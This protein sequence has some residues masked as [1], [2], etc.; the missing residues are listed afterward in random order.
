MRCLFAPL[1]LAILF[2]HLLLASAQAAAPLSAV[3][4][5]DS[6]PVVPSRL[7]LAAA[8]TL[9][10]QGNPGLRA[11]TRDVDI[12]AAQ[13][14]QAGTRPN[15]ALSYLSE[16]LQNDRRTT[17]VQ[18]DQTIELGGKRGARV[19]SAEREREIASADLASYRSELRADVVTAFFDVLTAQERLLLAQG[20]EQLSQQ[21]IKVA[22]HRVIAGK[23]SPV[24]ETRARV[25]G[26]SSRIELNQ[27][28]NQLAQ[29]RARLAATWGSTAPLSVEVEAPEQ[30]PGVHPSTAEL[31]AHVPAAPRVARARLEI[32][33]QKAR[34]DVERSRRIPDLT[35]SLGS[36]RDEQLGLRQT[37]VGLSV[38]IPLFDRNQGNLLSAL[39]RADKA[40]DE[41]LAAESSVSVELAQASLRLSAAT[42]E[43]NIL[44][45]EILPGAQS[46]YDVGVRGFELGK[47]SFLEVLDAQRTLFQAKTQ[48]VRALGES[49]RAA[50]DIERI[51]GTV[52]QH[53][54]LTSP[55]VQ[56]QEPK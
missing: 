27:A 53:G 41:L 49:H 56:D 26:A 44:R 46:A 24:E 12:A 1:G 28:A 48:Y 19:A 39:R 30:P 2:T 55:S 34:A 9:A 18:V 25:A 23:I 10:F 35:I 31:L 36:K 21:A 29:A 43:L 40:K 20:S 3:P 22:S 8:I 50:S 33:R 37:V 16:G 13:R 15:P 11:A 4:M 17:T 51:V 5:V 47:F 7:T 38:P 54:R 52:E 42:S 45:T 6:R 14:I 32:D